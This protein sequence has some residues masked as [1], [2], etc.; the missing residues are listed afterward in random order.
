MYR[1]PSGR[2]EANAPEPAEEAN[3]LPPL[4]HFA[5][6]VSR[7]EDMVLSGDPPYPIERT[8]LTTGTLDFLMRSA[9]RGGA[10]IETPELDVA[11]GL[12]VER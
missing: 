2:P 1:P 10:R 12:K 3:I 4:G 7:F 11:Y 5:F 9:A 8:L 6:L